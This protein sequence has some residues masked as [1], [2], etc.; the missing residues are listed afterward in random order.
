MYVLSC[1]FAT[2]HALGR[3]RDYVLDLAVTLTLTFA[4]DLD[5]DKA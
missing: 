5:L 1:A 4:F 2:G 3:E